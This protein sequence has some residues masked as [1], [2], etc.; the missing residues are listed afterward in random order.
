ML[1]V[2]PVGKKASYT[3]C[4]AKTPLEHL[5]IFSA[6]LAAAILKLMWTLYPLCVPEQCK[7]DA[8]SSD[9]EP[10]GYGHCGANP[11]QDWQSRNTGVRVCVCARMPVWE[12][13]HVMEVYGLSM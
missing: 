1:R 11:G 12:C 5:H 2:W 3:V 13:V 4:T 7:Q 9:G 10:P 8:T 6:T